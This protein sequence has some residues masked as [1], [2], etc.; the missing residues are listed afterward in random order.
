K[1]IALKTQQAKAMGKRFLQTQIGELES[2]V[3]TEVSRF[4]EKWAIK[5]K[6]KIG[7]KKLFSP[8][9]HHWCPNSAAPFVVS[10]SVAL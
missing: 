1:L 4:A 3:R 8:M 6:A 5:S 2:R 10:V 9:L 7:R